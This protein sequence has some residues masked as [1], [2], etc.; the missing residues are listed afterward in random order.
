MNIRT[1][2]NTKIERWGCLPLA[3][4]MS[5]SMALS[6]ALPLAVSLSLDLLVTSPSEAAPQGDEHINAKLKEAR[7]LTIAKK[8]KPALDDYLWIFEHSRNLPKWQGMRN[9]LVSQELVKLA[10]VY[11]PAKADVLK[12]RDDREQL[13]VANTATCADVQD[14]AM[15]NHNLKDDRR[16]VSIYKQLT[17]KGEATDKICDCIE[18]CIPVPLVRAKEYKELLPWAEKSAAEQIASVEESLRNGFSGRLALPLVMEDVYASY[19]VLLADGK[20]EE[21]NKLAQVILRP[22]S[23]HDMFVALVRAARRTGHPKIGEDLLAL[24]RKKVSATDYQ[25]IMGELK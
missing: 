15:L 23:S 22:W 16:S 10:E 13:I 24:A 9:A 19:E 5:F 25:L 1:M 7:L 20:E 21:A 4:A 8:Y 18:E 6:L 11:E 17:A 2:A 3:A 14:W 12:L